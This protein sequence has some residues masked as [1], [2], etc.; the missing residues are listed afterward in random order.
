[1]NLYIITI[2]N[3]II[4]YYKLEKTIYNNRAEKLNNKKK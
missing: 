4:I 3:S 1:M 2:D